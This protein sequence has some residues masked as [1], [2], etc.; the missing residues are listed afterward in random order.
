MG[1][2]R[3]LFSSKLVGSILAV[4]SGRSGEAKQAIVSLSRAGQQFENV[5]RCT[6][7]TG[8]S[9]AAAGVEQVAACHRLLAKFVVVSAQTM[10]WFVWSCLSYVGV[11]SSVCCTCGASTLDVFH[12]ALIEFI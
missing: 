3:L 4:D 9:F 1:I 5:S 12:D 2:P 10:S 11:A 7:L 6:A 8:T